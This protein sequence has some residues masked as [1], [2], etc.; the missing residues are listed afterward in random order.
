MRLLHSPT[1]TMHC[2]ARRLGL[3]VGALAAAGMSAAG[4]AAAQNYSEISVPNF[5]FEQPAIDGFTRGAPDNWTGAG[6]T[7]WQTADIAGLS[8]VTGD[9]VGYTNNNGL[10]TSSSLAEIEGKTQYRLRV[11]VG[12]R[13]FDP[14]EGYELQFYAGHPDEGGTVIQET[15]I[16]SPPP[17]NN[18]LEQAPAF[19]MFVGGPADAVGKPLHVALANAQNDGDTTDQ[20]VWDNVRLDKAS[21]N[22]NRLT[23]D[24]NQNTG[25]TTMVNPGSASESRTIS[26]YQ[27]SSESGSLDPSGWNSLAD[28]TAGDSGT[29]EEG[30]SASESMLFEGN[31]E[32]STTLDPGESLD[33]GAI[34]DTQG[35]EDLGFKFATPDSPPQFSLVDY[36][37]L[38]LL[39][40]DANNDG[41]V[42]AS[43]LTAI[44]N[45][46]GGSGT[47]DGTLIGDAN[48]D[49]V[50]DASDLTAI[51][52][53]FGESL[54]GGATANAVPAPASVAL[55][56]LGGVML[57]PRR[58]PRR[59]RQGRA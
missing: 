46:F 49:G 19:K 14:S 3:A 5:S 22:L 58:R 56:G 51:K 55:L 21:E 33:L 50:I 43:D 30:G 29:W 54:A 18:T 52:N 41:V 7:G 12:S 2:R 57:L 13:I 38:Q 11:D 27:V 31:I 39:F 6:N 34:F 15:G 42:D 24:V 16:I 35:S 40:G 36:S 44:K 17:A 47:D 26:S 48:D 9:Q 32:G 53:N 37:G 1:H 59:H 45:N 4:P 20:T 10:L 8:N 23:L 25:E 28:Q